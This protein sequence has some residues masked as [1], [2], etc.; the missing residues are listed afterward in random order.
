MA[1]KHLSFSMF[2]YCYIQ[3]LKKVPREKAKEE[4]GEM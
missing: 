4:S 3:C 1:E 2:L